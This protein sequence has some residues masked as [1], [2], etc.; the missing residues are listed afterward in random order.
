MSSEWYAHYYKMRAAL[1]AE[2]TEAAMSARAFYR[3]IVGSDA[4]VRLTVALRLQVTDGGQDWAI[5][6]ADGQRTAEF[7]DCYET[8]PLDDEE[9]YWLLELI[10]ASFEDH[11]RIQGADE[12]VAARV[13]GHLIESFATHRDTVE[14]WACLREPETTRF[15]VTPLMREVWEYCR[16]TRCTRPPPMTVATLGPAGPAAAPAGCHPDVKHTDVAEKGVCRWR[17]IQEYLPATCAVTSP[18]DTFMQSGRAT[19]DVQRRQERA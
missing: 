5:E 3:D 10:I 13:R 11:L 17:R 19:C 4:I 8:Q 9:R 16:T 1:F 14:Y 15:A 6:V 7:L 12:R 2:S 18:P